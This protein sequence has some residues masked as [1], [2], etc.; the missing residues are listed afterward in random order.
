[1]ETGKTYYQILELNENA[2]DEIKKA[3]RRLSFVYHPDKNLVTLIKL[4][5]L[6]N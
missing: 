4:N 6:N 2:T 5:Y 3:Y 1:M